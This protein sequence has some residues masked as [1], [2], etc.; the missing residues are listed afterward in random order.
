MATT[1][2]LKSTTVF[3]ELFK[4]YRAMAKLQKDIATD[5]DARPLAEMYLRN[6]VDQWNI[7]LEV[8]LW[9]DWDTDRTVD[10]V[11]GVITRYFT[12]KLY[13][14]AN[15]EDT[16]TLFGQARSLARDADVSLGAGSL[17]AFR[18]FL[19]A[20]VLNFLDE[21]RRIE[22]EQQRAN[23]YIRNYV[24]KE[25]DYANTQRGVAAPMPAGAVYTNVYDP[26]GQPDPVAM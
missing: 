10:A 16:A 17:D 26:P 11:T 1:V 24:Q 25:I 14:Y 6:K 9:D 21:A 23:V 7:Q 20:R 3:Q 8:A 18:E 15:T 2:P 4:A 13:N 12:P 19:Q 22:E 5:G